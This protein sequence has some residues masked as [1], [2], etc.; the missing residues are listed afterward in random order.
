MQ[1]LVPQSLHCLGVNCVGSGTIRSLRH[2]MEVFPWIRAGTPL[3]IQTQAHVSSIR[4]CNSWKEVEET[5]SSS[6]GK[7]G[8]WE[9]R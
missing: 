6:P 3:Y 4:K 9:N 5:G 8:Q 2:T 1:G 7:K